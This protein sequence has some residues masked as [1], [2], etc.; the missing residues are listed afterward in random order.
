MIPFRLF[1]AALGLTALLGACAAPPPEAAPA[2]S[3]AARELAPGQWQAPLP[4]GGQLG[5]LSTWWQRQ[6]DPLLVDLIDAAQQHSPSI[7]AASARIAQARANLGTARA[8]SVPTLDASASASRAQQATFPTTPPA[9]TVQAGLMAGWEIDLFGAQRAGVDAARQ[10]LA[11]A[12]AGW[13]DARVSVAAEVANLYIQLRACGV[14]AQLAQQDADSKASTLRLLEA[15]QKAGFAGGA[16]VELARASAHESLGQAMTTGAQCDALLKGL[17][18]LT[19][20][21]ESTLRGR[22]ATPSAAIPVPVALASVPAEVLSQRPDLYAAEREVT[23]AAQDLAGSQAQRYPRLTLGG[24]VA[25]M[26]VATPAVTTDFTTWSIG[27]LAL[28]VP[29]LDGGR[30]AAQVQAAQA[31][32]NEAAALYKAR[33]RSA[34]REVEEALIHLH[35]TAQRDVPT[36]AAAQAWRDALAATQTRQQHGLASALEV[37][38]ARRMA[39]AADAGELSLR[40]DRLLAWVSLYRAVGGGWERPSLRE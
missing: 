21:P 2:Q 31:R 8:A 13:H 18:A 26:N 6:G 24:S 29:L 33:V 3:L 12:E 39:L 20:L 16:Q 19:A 35:A 1:A 38:E 5:G 40:R 4:H 17:V 30:R 25:L 10:R 36:R 34:V 23:A 32:Y 9:N 15:S 28:S 22:L 11:G 14:Q 7:S 27:P 37:E